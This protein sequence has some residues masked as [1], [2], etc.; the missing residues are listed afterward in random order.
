MDYEVL[1]TLSPAQRDALQQIN[2]Q[3]LT[4]IQALYDEFHAQALAAGLDDDTATELVGWQSVALDYAQRLQYD[5]EHP[6]WRQRKADLL[7]AIDAVETPADRARWQARFEA[8]HP[9]DEE[10]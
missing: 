2:A 5:L 7:A 8:M 3:Y 6:N 1:E 10:E 4:R 9:D